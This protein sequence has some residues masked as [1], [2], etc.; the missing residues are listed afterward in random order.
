MDINYKN[1][2][3]K[4]KLASNN[5]YA[6][7]SKFYVGACV[8]FDDGSE[9]IG[10]NVENVSYGLSLCAERNAISSAIASGQK[11]KLLAVAISSENTKHCSPCGACRQ[12]IYEFSNEAEVILEK[13]NDDVIVYKIKDLL[14]EAF[15]L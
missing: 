9:H 14:P 2:I 8:L 12:W 11:G 13:N 7:Y 15:K 1:L 10:C 4:A 6:P 3:D 5:A